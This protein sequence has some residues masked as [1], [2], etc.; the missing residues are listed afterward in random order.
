MLVRTAEEDMMEDSGGTE[1]G[2]ATLGA[3]TEKKKQVRVMDGG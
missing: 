3:A 1:R 2:G